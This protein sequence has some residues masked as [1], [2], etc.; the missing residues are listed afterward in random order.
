MSPV[1]RL[2]G[3]C[4]PVVVSFCED[5]TG[6]VFAVVGRGR[7]LSFC[8]VGPTG[9]ARPVCGRVTGAGGSLGGCS[10]AA[11]R[12][13]GWG[14][15]AACLLGCRAT[16]AGVGA[17]NV[18]VCVGAGGLSAESAGY[19]G[20][21]SVGEV[22]AADEGGGS[23]SIAPGRKGDSLTGRSAAAVSTNGGRCGGSPLPGGREASLTARGVSGAPVR[24]DGGNCGSSLPGRVAIGFIGWGSPVGPT[25]CSGRSPGTVTPL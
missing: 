2:V 13:C 22:A 20:C 8:S 18:T 6:P 11:V 3:F 5:A 10:G 23:C 14:S 21:C 17:G 4:L 1:A 24:G 9:A 19:C 7:S 16:A 12:R 15:F 25:A